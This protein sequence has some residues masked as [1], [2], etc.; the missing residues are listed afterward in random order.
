[1]AEPG[2]AGA[3]LAAEAPRRTPRQAALSILSQSIA[4]KCQRADVWRAVAGRST[5]LPLPVCI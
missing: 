3:G 2:A 5:V 1:M 4:L